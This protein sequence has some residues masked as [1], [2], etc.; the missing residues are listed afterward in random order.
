MSGDFTIGRHL[1]TPKDLQGRPVDD[2]RQPIDELL[3]RGRA[4]IV[5]DFERVRFIDSAGLGEL[6]AFRKRAVGLGGDIRILHPGKQVEE[7]LV[8]TLLTDIFELY[9]DEDA[10]VRSFAGTR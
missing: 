2:L 3:S 6:I 1:G 5:L 7:V 8:L 9:H 10:A 4:R